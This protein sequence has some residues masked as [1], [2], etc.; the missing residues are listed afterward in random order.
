MTNTPTGIATTF[1]VLAILGLALLILRGLGGGRVGTYSSFGATLRRFPLPIAAVA[2]TVALLLGVSD[3]FGLARETTK[4]LF[5]SAII[6]FFWFL[7]VKLWQENTERS[8]ALSLAVAAAGLGLIAFHIHHVPYA[9]AYLIPGAILLATA[10]PFLTPNTTDNAS[11]WEFN[12]TAWFSA[13]LG[14]TAALILTGGI[15]GAFE[16]VHWA[17]DLTGIN[18]FYFSTYLIS[19]FIFVWSVLALAGVPRAFRV[20]SIAVPKILRFFAG[21]LLLPLVVIY[22]AILYV[23]LGKIIVLWELP[24]GQVAALVSIFAT[25]GVVTYLAVYPLRQDG[26]AIRLFSRVFFPALLPLVG[27]LTMALA[28]RIGAYGV[29]ADRYLV[30]L[31]GLWLT[32]SALGFIA[33]KPPLKVLPLSLAGLLLLASIGPWSAGAVST[34]SQLA[35]L[36]HVLK[37][38]GI[39]IGGKIV[40]ASETAVLLSADRARISSIVLYLTR[41]GTRNHLNEWMNARNFDVSTL[42][43]HEIARKLGLNT[44]APRGKH[45]YLSRRKQIVTID[46]AGFDRLQHIRCRGTGVCNHTDQDWIEIRGDDLTVTVPDDTRLTFDL[47]PLLELKDRQKTPERDEQMAFDVSFNNHRARL[48]LESAHGFTKDG[49]LTLTALK[50]V[51]LLGPED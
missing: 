49:R 51:L 41:S 17:F 5:P 46:V 23:Y 2:V 13:I 29:T 14:A 31:F 15:Y 40:P 22:L 35:E 3:E 30:G 11:Y 4:T 6:G 16:L 21:R 36:E 18:R 34:R 43:S 32:V 19:A 10:A 20:E 39:L 1:I 44:A 50:G 7:A 25:L 12:C 8:W 33:F 45:I 42:R 47:A 28:A 27:L 38:T 9:A 37:R 26:A 24:K 48:I